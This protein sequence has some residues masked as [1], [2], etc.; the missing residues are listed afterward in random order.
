MIRRATPA[1]RDAVERIITEA[2]AV[3]IGRMGKP[4]GPMLNDYGA[5]IAAGT[6][7]VLKPDDQPIAAVIVLLEKADHLL[8][9]NIAVRRDRQ[10]QGLGRQLIAFVEDEAR[11]LGFAEIRLY[12]HVTMVENIALYMRLGFVETGR[13]R[14]GGYDRV[15]MAKGLG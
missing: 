15:F 9:D 3:Y 4:P 10:G 13:G 8:L 2:Y 14:D 5:L 12:T 11:R 7:H 1:D 6:V